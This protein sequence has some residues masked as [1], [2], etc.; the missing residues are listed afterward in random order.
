MS[1]LNSK[2]GKYCAFE[3]QN[4]TWDFSTHVRNSGQIL[5]SWR[6]S[7]INIEKTEVKMEHVASFSGI[8]VTCKSCLWRK[9][10]AQVL[11]HLLGKILI[12]IAFLVLGIAKRNASPLSGGV[13]LNKAERREERKRDARSSN[14]KAY[15]PDFSSG[16][17]LSKH[18]CSCL[19]SQIKMYFKITKV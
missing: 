6:Q 8:P 7:K 4:L 11:Y 16:L 13:F 2:H 19:I 10:L 17:N 18:R 1:L 5:I 15:I 12:L 14:I 3:E 9:T